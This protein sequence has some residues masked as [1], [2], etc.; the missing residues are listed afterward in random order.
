MGGGQ[1]CIL[2]GS[3]CV[4]VSVLTCLPCEDSWTSELTQRLR[5]FLGNVLTSKD[6]AKVPR[7]VQMYRECEGGKPSS[8]VQGVESVKLEL[9]NAHLKYAK[10]ANKL[11]EITHS[12]HSLVGISTEMVM[13]LET[14]VKEKMV[15]ISDWE[16]GGGDYVGV[17]GGGLGQVNGSCSIAR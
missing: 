5:D 9:A 3:V 1:A 14:A 10:V 11:K 15:G 6:Q 4:C 8:S 2:V 12:Y 16:G 7:L 13:A 17:G